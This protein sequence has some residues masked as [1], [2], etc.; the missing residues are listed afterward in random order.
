MASNS[1]NDLSQFTTEMITLEHIT[2][3]KDIFLPN[4]QAKSRQLELNE[5]Y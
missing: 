1:K 5:V 4:D 2:K 3:L